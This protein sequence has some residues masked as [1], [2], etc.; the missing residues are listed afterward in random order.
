MKV[1]LDIDVWKA[2][3]TIEQVAKGIKSLKPSEVL[4]DAA[5]PGKMLLLD[6]A[7]YGVYARALPKGAK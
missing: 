6:L 3:L 5:G 7:K 1:V 2:G 4:I